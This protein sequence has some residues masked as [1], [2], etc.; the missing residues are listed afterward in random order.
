MPTKYL[1]DY[2]QP[3]YLVD[4]VDLT[5]E[6]NADES[7]SVINI[8][9]YHKTPVVTT[10]T[11]LLDGNAKLEKIILN[12]IDLTAAQYQKQE[13]GILLS[14]L[15][16]SFTLEVHTLLHPR[17]NKSC[18]GLF[19]SHDIFVTQCE[20]EGFREM[21]YF[22]DRPDVLARFTTTIIVDNKKYPVALSN[23]NR[24]ATEINTTGR[25]IIKWEDPFRKPA[26]LFALV[27]GDLGV[28]K[29]TF[30]T[31]SGRNIA[32]E[33]YSEHKNIP[34][35]THAME[36]LKRAMRWDETRFNLE[37][38]LDT[39]MIVAS[40]DFNMGAMENKGLNVFN[41]KYI[42][43]DKDTATDLDFITIEAVIGHE[44]FHNWTGNRVTCR[45]WFQLSLKEGLTVFRDHEFTAD[46][47]NRSVQRINNVMRLHQTQF[48]EDGGPLAHAVRPES[49]MEINNFYTSTIYEKGSEV[50]R[51][52]QTIL[53]RDGFNRGLTLYLERHD[54]TAATCEDFYA[55]MVDANNGVHLDKFMLWYSQA[56]TPCLTVHEEYNSTNAEY[57]L[58]FEQHTPDT[59]GQTNKQA[60]LIPIKLGLF[61]PDGEEL[62]N[63]TPIEGKYIQHADGLVLLLTD[64]TNKFVFKHITT[65]P[66]PS[67]LRG[68]SAPV[69]L[70]LDMPYAH[71]LFLVKHDSDEFN[72]LQCLKNII[73][74]K[75]KAVYTQLAT[76]KQALAIA[77]PDFLQTLRDLL[78]DDTIDPDAR[79]LAFQFPTFLE[80]VATM[81]DVQP[82][83][84]TASINT[85][86]QQIGIELF[87]SFMEIYELH[88]KRSYSFDDH[89][90][91]ALKNTALFYICRAM[92]AKLDNEKS[93][94]FIETI[95]LGQYHN[96]DNM[97]DS[98]AVLTAVNDLN[99][100][101]RDT[102]LAEFYIKWQHNELV[103]DKWFMLHATCQHITINRLNQLMVDPTFIATNPNKIYA[104]IRAFTNNSRQF[105]NEAGYA[106]VADQIINVD[107]FNPHVAGT[108][109][110]GFNS[111]VY[112]APRYRSMAQ[113]ALQR[114]LQQQHISDGV[115]EISTQILSSIT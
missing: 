44:Y 105:H 30:T 21:T 87:D 111:V 108:V 71:Q 28:L 50:V 73:Y 84:L 76:T 23:G 5:F 4:T 69:K 98:V 29:D 31:K 10:N 43:A 11:L 110:R 88:L 103:M 22:Q 24:I 1:K 27:I 85:L 78:T 115:K 14:D 40:S 16:D 38:D 86:Q 48:V 8:A 82:E 49:Y 64:T 100:S 63:I 112:L 57:T 70:T 74:T 92:A 67:V 99:I 53:G 6:L 15:P 58:H 65:Q 12:N 45:D 55:A 59:P 80:I 20:P 61:Y 33:I 104:L 101:I 41:A 56:G 77:D 91:R 9:K 60:L 72:R 54:G 19:T 47:H 95:A 96:T 32:L 89:G 109:A 26:Y 46:L 79:A 2:T 102:M 42:L 37:Y 18:M 75:V 113:H 51:M 97:T 36:S 39:Y 94:Q 66:I 93:L 62:P 114:I 34:R 3:N 25:R 83:I 13:A 7:V 35:C 17:I 106:F 68:F 52:Y 81:H 90:S 107:K